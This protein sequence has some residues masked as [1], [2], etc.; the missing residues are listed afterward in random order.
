MIAWRG[1][2]AA[3]TNSF[4]TAPKP[5]PLKEFVKLESVSLNNVCEQDG[6]S[7]HEVFVPDVDCAIGAGGTMEE[8]FAAAKEK[9]TDMVSDFMYRGEAIPTPSLPA[10]I[11][12][13]RQ[14]DNEQF[15]GFVVTFVGVII[16]STLHSLCYKAG[17]PRE[18]LLC[19]DV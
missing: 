3:P 8:A 17:Q 4:H 15:A 13:R 10:D 6:Y 9:L 11:I 12:T 2:H 18:L 5:S 19:H 7:C 14:Q 1:G 16:V